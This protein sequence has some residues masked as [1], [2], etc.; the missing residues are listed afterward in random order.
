MSRRR[1]TLAQL[2]AV[3]LCFGLAF[4]AL[5]RADEVWASATYT[6]VFLMISLAPICALARK[7]RARLVWAG[8]AVFGWAR[9]LV[10]VLPQLYLRSMGLHT[11]TSPRLLTEWAFGYLQP[12]LPVGLGG[13]IPRP[14]QWAYYSLE[15]IVFALTGAVFGYLLF[16]EED[17]QTA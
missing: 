6:L 7:G 13:G 8:F 1:F 17:R 12:Y 15:I 5:R 3:V 11:M 9:L 4:A 16:V 10:G 2:M 14:C